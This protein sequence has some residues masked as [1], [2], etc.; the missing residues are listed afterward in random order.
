MAPELTLWVRKRCFMRLTAGTPS[1]LC[2]CARAPIPFVWETL[3]TGERAVMTFYKDDQETNEIAL[4]PEAKN[5]NSRTT[6]MRLL[7]RKQY[8]RS[9]PRSQTRNLITCPHGPPSRDTGRMPHDHP[10]TRA[11]FGLRAWDTRTTHFPAT[12]KAHAHVLTGSQNWMLCIRRPAPR[13]GHPAARNRRSASSEH[14]ERRYDLASAPTAARL[15]DEPMQ[16][17]AAAF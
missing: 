9:P 11:D 14:R 6:S 3:D 10:I 8:T 16:R 2:T 17:R 13:N 15:Q 5:G 7:I 12:T 4:T 1:A